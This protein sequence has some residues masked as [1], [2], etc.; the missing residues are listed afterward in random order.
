LFKENILEYD[1][2][3]IVSIVALPVICN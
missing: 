1:R 3:K 2:V